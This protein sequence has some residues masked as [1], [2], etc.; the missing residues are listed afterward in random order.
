MLELVLGPVESG[1]AT[2]IRSNNDDR[3][4][5]HYI[6]GRVLVRGT[7]VQTLAAIA[8]HPMADCLVAR[9][10]AAYER[11]PLWL[12]LGSYVLAHGAVDPLMAPSTRRRRTSC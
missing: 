2:L 5:R 8:S 12:R 7:L 10:C 3:L 4:Y 9:F 1:R 6:K 11:A